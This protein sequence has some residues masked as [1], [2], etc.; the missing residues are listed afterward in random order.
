[1][2]TWWYL[3]RISLGPWD[4]MLDSSTTIRE[5]STDFDFPE[6]TFGRLRS[7]CLEEWS[8]EE[9]TEF[10]QLMIS[11]LIRGSQVDSCIGSLQTSVMSRGCFMSY[12][13]VWDPGDFTFYGVLVF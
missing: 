1:M 12:M 7:G 9:L 8:S 11:W 13:L 3:S 4:Y 6:F 5:E 2:S 10:M